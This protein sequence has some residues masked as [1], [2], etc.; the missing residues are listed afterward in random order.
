MSRRQRQPA[1]SVNF[2]VGDKVRVKQGIR[3]TNYPDMPLG[4]WAGSIAE[5]LKD[6]MYTV[7]WSK[8]TL[9]AIH[10]V[11][12]KRCER[13]GM[14]LEEYWLG[15]DDL[16]PDPGGPLDIEH[17]KKITTKPLSTKDQDDRIRIVLGL[18]SNDPL[19]DVASETLERY[20]EHLLEHLSFPFD[21]E[22]TSETGPFSS[23]TIQVK[24]TGLGDPEEPMIDDM[25]GIICE[26]KHERRSIDL[27][28]DELE[29]KKNKSNRQ[30]IE[31]YSYWLHNWS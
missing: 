31:D 7:R 5:I 1:T 26:A 28:L 29:V 19:P 4:G 27:P 10:P 14:V 22:Y 3:D 2:K 20:H 16:G 15:E 21:A 12:K 17:P 11:F 6:G 24:V 23:R 30:L 9:D 13:D 25:Y 18:T 8:V